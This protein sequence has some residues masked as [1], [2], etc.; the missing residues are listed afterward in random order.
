MIQTTCRKKRL[1]CVI[2]DSKK[3]G[4]KMVIDA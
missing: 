2:A 4:R 3:G 1:M